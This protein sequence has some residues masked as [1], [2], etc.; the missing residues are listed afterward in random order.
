MMSSSDIPS[1]PGRN[2]GGP[3]EANESEARVGARQA[4]VENHDAVGPR[5][6]GEDLDGLVL[7]RSCRAPLF[8]CDLGGLG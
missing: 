5:I 6:Y 4:C 8:Y 3:A 7:C 2:A 1:I